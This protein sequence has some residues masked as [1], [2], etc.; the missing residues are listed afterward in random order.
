MDVNS[1]R[2]IETEIRRLKS[3]SDTIAVELKKQKEGTIAI[4]NEFKW[5]HTEL[6]GLKKTLSDIETLTNQTI[7]ADVTFIREKVTDLT[8]FIFKIGKP[9]GQPKENA[10]VTT[11]P[12]PTNSTTTK[13]SGFFSG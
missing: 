9:P 6:K 8:N 3:T 2:A 12:S 4:Q 1:I 5:L 13:R 11:T 10:T 7:H